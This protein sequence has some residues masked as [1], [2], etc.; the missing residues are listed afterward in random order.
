MKSDGGGWGEEKN[1]HAYKEKGKAKKLCSEEGKG[2]KDMQ[3]QKYA[4]EAMAE[5]KSCKLK[6]LSP[7]VFRQWSV[8]KKYKDFYEMG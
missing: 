2:K 5:K 3:L 4:T 8:P 7:S 1:K 6:I